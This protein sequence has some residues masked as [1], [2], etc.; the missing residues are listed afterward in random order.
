MKPVIIETPYKGETAQNLRYLRE[1]IKDS[2]NRGEA[3]FA[4]HLMYTQVLDDSKPDERALG[5]QAGFAWRTCLTPTIVYTDLGIS[6][7][8]KQGILHAESVGSPIEYRS[9]Y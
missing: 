6:E 1:C 5:I 3:P 7:G 4:S 2:L 9:L 8:M